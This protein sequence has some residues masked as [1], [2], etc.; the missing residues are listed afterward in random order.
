MIGR[1]ALSR[2]KPGAILVNTARGGIVDEAALAEALKSG[3]VLAAGL[4]VFEKE[5]PDT[6]QPSAGVAQRRADP[7][8]FGGNA[9]RHAAKNGSDLRQSRPLLPRRTARQSGQIPIVMKADCHVHILDPARFPYRTD[10][11]YSPAPHET[12]VAEQLIGVFDAHGITHG[13]VVT[14]MAGYQSNNTVTLDALTRYP[15]RLRGIAV[16]ESDVAESEIDRLVR[17]SIL[18][19]RIDLIGR[20]TDY[21]RDAGGKRLL[22]MMRDRRLITQIQCEFDQLADVGAILS[23]EAGSL[24]IDHAARPDAGRGLHQPG[25]KALLK[26]SERDDVAVKLSGPFRFSRSGYPFADAIPYMRKVYEAFG[27]SR[28][29]WG[30]DWPFSI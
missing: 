21:V 23:A 16:V 12:A 11:I 15:K 20:G 28:C 26:L 22:N 1:D 8:H 9:R 18:G 3:R 6:A 19:I 2:L 5:P 29:V 24:V 25:F 27:A 14:P 17:H 7:A 10:T 13:L 30:S 4:D